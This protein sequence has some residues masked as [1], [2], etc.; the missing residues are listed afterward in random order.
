MNINNNNNNIYN[1]IYK[2]ENKNDVNSVYS[3]NDTNSVNDTSDVQ[4]SINSFYSP[5]NN[6]LGMSNYNIQAMSLGLSVH[7]H[8]D[9]NKNIFKYYLHHYMNESIAAYYCSDKK[10]SAS[11]KYYI[12][13]KKF[14]IASEHSIPFEKHCYVS[15]PFPNDQRLFKEFAKRNFSEAQLFKQ[16]NKRSN[17]FWYNC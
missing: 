17:I 12:E 6:S 11:A 14:E 13:T 10:C 16:A 3:G 8:K 9:E 1:S 4:S 2:N 15:K 7:L 5:L